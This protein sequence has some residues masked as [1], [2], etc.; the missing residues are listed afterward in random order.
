[1]T[2]LVDFLAAS[3][4]RPLSLA[5]VAWLALRLG[6]IRHPASQHAVWTAVLI[7]LLTL[8]IVS[9]IAPHWSIPVLPEKQPP[10]IAAPFAPPVDYEPIA[11]EAPLV[12]ASMPVA[13]QF[14]FRSFLIVCCYV[15]GLLMM[16][17]YRSI[18]WVLLRR[19]VSRSTQSRAP[20]LRES[21]DVST[22]FAVGIM[23]PCV[24]LPKGWRAWDPGKRRAVLAHEFAHLRRRDALILALARFGKCLFWFHPLAWYLSRK[25]SNLAELACDAEALEKVS[26][27]GQYSR[28]LLEFAAAVN[29]SGS[30]VALP[31][32]AMAASSNISRRIDHVFD[33]CNRAPRR[34]ARPAIVLALIGAPLVCAAATFSIGSRIALPILSAPQA[35]VPPDA[36]LTAPTQTGAASAPNALS[37]K[38]KFEVAS[39]R[40][41]CDTPDNLQSSSPGRLTLNCMRV[42][43]LIQRA[44]DYG[45]SNDGGFPQLH[46]WTPIEG[47]P[48]WI[49]SAQNEFQITATAANGASTALMNGPM[50]QSLLE[51]RFKL[52][53]HRET[54]QVPV[55]A[56][57]LGK[58][59]PKFQ[60][61]KP[62]DC[63][64]YSPGLKLKSGEYVCDRVRLSMAIAG[65]KMSFRGA[66]IL[67]LARDLS[68]RL[69]RPVID[70]TGLSGTFNINLEFEPDDDTPTLHH[71]PISLGGTNIF[72]AVQEQLGLKLEST[73]GQGEFL[74]IDSV[75][76]P[77]ED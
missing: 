14:P 76:M 37:P 35:P 55:F 12:P 56:L 11:A 22:P 27:P 38:P 32:L 59:G 61:S 69:N 63:L 74:V 20:W 57:V 40:R 39:I 17:A 71:M 31:G 25:L 4:V 47:G 6:R 45:D 7:G 65:T 2:W 15:A 28:I 51:D 58:G 48:S 68:Y 33:L 34:L 9:V 52:K 62:G 46:M 18:G 66:S 29:D 26:D 3:L 24:I 30:R 67:T 53:I 49:D 1:M 73:K 36:Q 64:P 42:K 19:I 41:G 54:R 72:T 75:E 77:T 60:A 44:Y 50:L 13:P 21:A 16:L 70:R 43:Y 10:A 23:L 8:P 5:A